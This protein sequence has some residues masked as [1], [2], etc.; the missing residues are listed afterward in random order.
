MAKKNR[1]SNPVE[2]DVEINPMTDRPYTLFETAGDLII[3]AESLLTCAKYSL[4]YKDHPGTLIDGE[5]PEEGSDSEIKLMHDC[6][7]ILH[8]IYELLDADDS[9]RSRERRATEKKGDR[10]TKKSEARNARPLMTN[11]RIAS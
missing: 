4:Q 11:M 10:K 8:D 3:Q 5:D 9:A 7:K 1:E 6:G 2:P